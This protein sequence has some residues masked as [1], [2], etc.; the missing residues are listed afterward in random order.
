MVIVTGNVKGAGTDAKVSLIIFGKTGQTAKL[1]LRSNSKSSFERNQSDIFNLKTT[2][3]GPMTKIRY[4]SSFAASLCRLVGFCREFA[5]IGTFL[6]VVQ[7]FIT[8]L[9][10]SFHPNMGFSLGHL[11]L[12][13]DNCFDVFCSISSRRSHSNLLLL[14]TIGSIFAS[15]KNSSFL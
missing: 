9:T 7:G 13:L 15:S 12:H 11:H 14:M 10:V 4:F 8:L 1:Y 6:N 5:V 3:V 2:C